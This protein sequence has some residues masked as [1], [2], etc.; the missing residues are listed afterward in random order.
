MKQQKKNSIKDFHNSI[1]AT[2]LIIICSVSVYYNSLNAPFI[3]DDTRVIENLDIQ[4]LN[5]IGLILTKYD[6][7][8]TYLTFLLN[9]HFNKQNTFG[10]HLFNVI[11]HTLTSILVFFL[12]KRIVFFTNNR[13]SI[14]LPLTVSLVFAVHPINTEVVTY[15]YNRSSSLSALFYLLSLLLFLNTIMTE[16]KFQRLYFGLSLISFILSFFSKQISITLPV[17]IFILDY[18]FLSD[19]NI[20]KVVSRKKFHITYWSLLIVLLLLQYTVL[21]N[22]KE[23]KEETSWTLIS[24][25]I[26]QPWLITKYLQLITVPTG[27]CINHIIK[28]V[29]T[30]LELRFILPFLIISGIFISA[31]VLYRKRQNKIILFSILF[32]F[33]T[34]IPTTLFIVHIGE[35]HLY[36]P[37]LG[38]YLGLSNIIFLCFKKELFINKNLILI[39]IFATY[40]FILSVLTIK[41]NRLYN[42]PILMWQDAII[43][44]PDNVVAYNNRGNAYLNKGEYDRAISDCSEAIRLDKNNAKAYYNRG[45]AYAYKR[46]Y[47]KALYDYNKAIEID[48]NYADAYHNRGMVY[49]ALNEYDKSVMDYTRATELK[50]YFAKAYKN[51]GYIYYLKGYYDNAINDYTQAIKIDPEY[52][53]AYY[54]RALVYD[55]KNEYEKASI[56]YNRAKNLNPNFSI[57]SKNLVT[58]KVDSES[59]YY[60]NRGYEYAMNG[61]YEKAIMEFSQAIKLDPKYAKAYCNRGNTYYMKKEYDK[62]IMDYKKSIELDPK[63]IDAYMNLGAVYFNKGEYDKAIIEYTHVIEIDPKYAKAYFNRGDTYLRKKEYD[64]A[65]QDFNLLENSGYKIDNKLMEF[66]R[67]NVKK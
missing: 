51:R 31:S 15:I 42:D 35:R 54:Y 22:I 3:Y 4:K 36:L 2:I 7:Q 25:Y 1:I 55:K 62:A 9:Y 43:K 41:R 67:K 50:P 18:I 37:A 11:I 63:Y 12:I 65:L 47:D 46:I 39:T 59:D 49:Y 24:Y 23:M 21:R 44:Y 28:P 20:T 27:Q 38:F 30:I 32:F 57:P 26:T 29:K 66:L 6:R 40:I 17:I 56:D 52:A 45:N 8:L 16:T 33:I 61:N 58:K 48:Q 13:N 34:L 19:F 53:E 10:Y 14:L 64:K 5:N 60:F